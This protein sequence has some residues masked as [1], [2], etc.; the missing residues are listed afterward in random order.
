[1]MLDGDIM[2]FRRNGG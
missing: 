1:M 2:G